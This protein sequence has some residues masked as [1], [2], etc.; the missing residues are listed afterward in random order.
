MDGST[1]LENRQHNN[2]EKQ[3]VMKSR[4]QMSTCIDKAALYAWLVYRA[5]KGLFV[6]QQLLLAEENWTGLFVERK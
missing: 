6:E 4:V 2:K 5:K 3:S 1:V